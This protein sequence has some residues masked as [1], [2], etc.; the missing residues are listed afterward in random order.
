MAKKPSVKIMATLAPY[1]DHRAE[2][3]GHPLVSELRL[4]TVMPIAETKQELLTRLKNECRGKKLWLDLKTRQLRITKFAYLPYAYVELSHKIKVNLPATIYFKDCTA[5]IVEI[6][7]G[8]KLILAERPLRTV[9]EGEPVNILDPSLEIEKFLTFGDLEYVEAAKKL[10]L[11]NYLL[12]FVE[13][14]QDIVD[15]LWVDPQATII[16]KIES[17]RGLDF[18]QTGYKSLIESQRGLYLPQIG[19]KSYKKRVQLMAARDD[20]YINMGEQKT[21]VLRALATIVKANPQAY[22]ASRLLTSLEEADTVALQDLS[23]LQ[24]MLLLGFSNFLLSDMLCFRHTA[25][26][27][28]MAVLSEFFPIRRK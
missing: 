21:E 9:G 8:N 6:F 11:H 19:Y 2:V 13:K 28:T 16:A 3:I 26:T 12:S 10:G 20:L 25:F 7:N 15:L 17:K 27:K 18:V 5:K 14:R 23:D 1:V 4:N 22:C 24:L